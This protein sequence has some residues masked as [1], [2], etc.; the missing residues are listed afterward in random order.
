MSG[1]LRRQ[2]ELV[3]EPRMMLSLVEF[4]L[5][6]SRKSVLVGHNPVLLK[7][8]LGLDL[9]SEWWHVQVGDGVLVYE[10]PELL[11]LVCQKLLVLLRDPLQ[12]KIGIDS[13][14]MVVRLMSQ[15]RVN[16]YSLQYFGGIVQW[17]LEF[18]EE[19]I[20][21]EQESQKM[22]ALCLVVS[23]FKYDQDS[24]QSILDMVRKVIS[25]SFYKSRMRAVKFLKVLYNY[26]IIYILQYLLYNNINVD[27]EKY[28]EEFSFLLLDQQK[29]VQVQAQNLLSM[30][31]STLLPQQLETLVEY[32]I[33]LTDSLLGKAGLISILKSQ[34]NLT[35]SWTNRALSAVLMGTRRNQP[36]LLSQ[37]KDFAAYFQKLYKANYLSDQMEFPLDNEVLQML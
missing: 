33:N 2:L 6:L 27:R 35:S 8:L 16:S 9:P 17:L 30:L 3:N 32:F 28:I 37:V 24:F 21:N 20:G 15:E 26:N 7:Q 13:V 11:V 14:G 1:L 25:S 4:V 31:V 18:R 22:S 12:C 36:E 34:T 5:C 23:Q 29:V 19:D 10:P